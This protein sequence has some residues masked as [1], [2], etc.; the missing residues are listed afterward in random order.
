[1]LASELS[2]IYAWSIDFYRIQKNDAFKVVFEERF[3]DGV[4]V[5]IGEI[6][7]AYFK[8][9]KE[10]NYAIWFEQD[11]IGDYYDQDNRSL[12]KAFLKAPLKFSRISSRYTKKRF[13]PVQKR[14]KAHLGTDYAAP[15]GTPIRTVADGT[16]IAAKYSKYN[17]NYVK[18]KHNG[19]YT[20]QYLHMSKIK[21][22]IRKGK[23]VRQGDVIGYVGATGLATGPHLCYRFWKN[24]KQVDPYKQKMPASKPISKGNTEK[25]NEI[26]KRVIKELDD[27]KYM[28]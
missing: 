14:F 25:Y 20:T 26:K 23:R 19:T 22:G 21:S 7:Y 11:Q 17:G 28:N 8:H 13:H 3:V 15:T 2:E 24:G 27:I 16:V 1:M 12:R 9:R 10:D 18:V 4:S 6:K 5:G